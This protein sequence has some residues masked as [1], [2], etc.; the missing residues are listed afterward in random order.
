MKDDYK[1]ILIRDLT[2]EDNK[3]LTEVR[4]LTGKG[5]NTKALMEAARL[6]VKLD[7]EARELRIE[8]S[9]LKEENTNIKFKLRDY[10]NLQQTLKD[11]TKGLPK[12]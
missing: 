5:N 11:F 8:T 12:W 3:L 9:K 10:F 6:F 1:H 7:N 2:E 4:K